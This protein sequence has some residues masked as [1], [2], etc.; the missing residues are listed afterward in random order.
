[1]LPAFEKDCNV[2]VRT[3]AVGTGEAL[4][5]GE[6]GDADAL[7]VHAKSSEEEFVKK[8][9]G[10][11]RVEIMWNDF[12]IVGPK[13]DTA[14]I[15]G[16]TNAVEAFKKIALR[17]VTFVSRADDSGTN[18]KELS[19][20]KEAGIDPHG[21][22]WYVEAGQGMGEVLAM[23]SEKQGYTLSD[24]ATFI[25][26]RES[27]K[28][29]ILVEKDKSLV[30]PYSVIVVNPK[31]FPDLK[32]NTEGAGE[33]AWFV[34]GEKGQELIGKYEKEG[35]QLFHPCAKEQT[36]GLGGLKL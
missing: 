22:P 6:K 31:E 4:K 13:S 10:L 24:R 18:K 21:K 33:F 32:L 8:G 14:N 19:L 11:E 15:K 26:M 7:L 17:G 36:R 2:K 12:V 30:N 9:Y 5:M 3:I 28:L 16:G 25:F 1:M 20:W 29:K 27:L 35:F 23:T 34:T